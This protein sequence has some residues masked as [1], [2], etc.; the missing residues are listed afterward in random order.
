MS[1][2]APSLNPAAREDVEDLEQ[3]EGHEL[4]L[5][6]MLTDYFDK[7]TALTYGELTLVRAHAPVPVWRVYHDGQQI[8]T[9]NLARTPSVGAFNRILKKYHKSLTAG[10][11][12]ARPD[13][14]RG[15]FR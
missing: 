2:T 8:D 4:R 6:A 14:A 7:G 13:N 9:W 5:D 12:G 15:M 1:K 10:D 3:F 11:E